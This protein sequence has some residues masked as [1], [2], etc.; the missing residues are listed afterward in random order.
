MQ[1]A[2]ARAELVPAGA[3]TGWIARE[4]GRQ[5]GVLQL[6]RVAGD[7]PSPGPA[8]REHGGE[9]DDVVLDDHVWLE[10]AEDLAQ[11]LVDVARPIDELLPDGKDERL[12]LLDR[13]LAELGRRVAD[14]FLPELAGRLLDLRRRL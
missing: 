4:R 10:L 13:G 6:E 12:E 14:E 8:A 1:L 3:V 9:G 5:L 11:P 7:D 2:V